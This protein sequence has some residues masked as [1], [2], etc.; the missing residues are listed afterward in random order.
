MRRP[1]FRF[2]SAAAMLLTA[3]SLAAPV[4]ADENTPPQL[5]TPDRIETHL[6]RLEFRDGIPTEA[7]AEKLYSYLDLTRGVESFLNGFSG[8]SMYAI[9]QGFRDAG[10]EDG[11]VLIFSGLMDSKSLFLTANA[12][13]IY[14]WSYLDL[15]KGPL[16]VE[17][18]PQ[19]LGIFD[20]MWFRWI[21][22]FGLAGP[23]RG[24]GG[25]YL[26]LPPGY[27]GPLPEGGYFIARSRT[28]GV[29]LIARAFLENNDPAPAVA[30]I[31]SG[32]K[33]Y[34]Y[35]A[36]SY[37]SSVG[38]FLNGKGA[39][40]QLS[41][42]ATPKFVEGTG[43]EMNTVPPND[44]SF[45]EMLD[46]LV[47]EE[48]AEALDPELAGQFAGIGIV[49]GK[50]FDPDDRMRNLLATAAI[51][52]N[53]ASRTV[54]TRA[55]PSEGFAYYTDTKSYWSNPLFAGGYEFMNPPPEITK[56][57]VKPYPS[58]GARTLDARTSFFYLATVITPAMVMR[59]TNIGSQYLA[60][61]YDAEGNPFDGAKTYKVKLPPE[62]PAAKFWS[63]TVYD[64]QT[65]SMLQTEQRF[66]R[67]GS[68]SFPTPAALA[69]EDGST[70]IYFGPKR[71]DDVKEG[72]WIQ[73]V[74]GKGWFVILRLYSPLE[75]FFDK[76]WRPGEIDEVK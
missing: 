63:L 75:T 49:K 1:A 32:L 18:P 23:D 57:G 37:G 35:V 17:V 15:S 47:Q 36:G 56:E 76:T 45:Y 14:F 65:R 40:G 22:D 69:N 55:R 6:G 21:V 34:P 5:T 52:G 72:N 46:S 9:R 39:L 28:N 29:G 61:F 62:I 53:A 8:V 33:I 26:L 50:S 54:G 58:T 60:T 7:T 42:P 44:A 66:P 43:R 4:V 30:R 19:S 31:K 3:T 25:K 10:V 51:I 38:A 13:T 73:T 67:A 70:V 64:N 68:Q 27:R 74:P 48:P 41:E 11:D 59:L 20:D 12:D 24:Q 2:F 16:V 71:P